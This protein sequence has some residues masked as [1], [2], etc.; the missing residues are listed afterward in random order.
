MKQCSRCKKIKNLSEFNLVRTGGKPRSACKVCSTEHR[1]IQSKI[2]GSPDW[3]MRRYGRLKR[4]AK[5]RE[6]EFHLTFNEAKELWSIKNCYYCEE[7][8]LIQTID[9][10]DNKGPYKKQNCVMACWDCNRIKSYMSFD[11]IEMFYKK[12]LPYKEQP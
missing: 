8:A 1:R 6:K 7:H 5:K 2:V 10:V 4:Q 9:R 3:W 11:Q 12:T